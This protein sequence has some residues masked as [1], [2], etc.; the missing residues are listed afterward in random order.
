[1]NIKPL[2]IKIVIIVFVSYC[3]WLI[4]WWFLFFQLG[5]T[6]VD[7]FYLF[8][9]IYNINKIN[10]IKTF[11][12]GRFSLWSMTHLWWFW[13]ST[14]K[15]CCDQC[16]IDF[17]KKKFIKDIFFS[18]YAKSCTFLWHHILNQHI[19]INIMYLSSITHYNIVILIPLC[20]NCKICTYWYHLVWAFIFLLQYLY[21]HGI[22]I[23]EKIKYPY[24]MG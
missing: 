17:W 10:N 8:Y 19:H 6:C 11:Q 1:M 24:Q 18:T 22:Q 21:C 2:Q 5:F 15:F 3:I 16:F 13:E 14:N 7:E 12:C 23:S 20:E 4:K 9:V